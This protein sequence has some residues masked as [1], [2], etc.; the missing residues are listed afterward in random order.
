MTD[1]IVAAPQTGSGPGVAVLYA[2]ST[3]E[4]GMREICTA[5]GEEGY[6]AIAHFIPPGTNR[7]DGDTDSAD[8]AVA[9][10]RRHKSH[11]GRI[12]AISFGAAAQNGLAL[13]ANRLVDCLVLYE[14]SDTNNIAGDLARVHVPVA[15][16]LP[17]RGSG[18]TGDSGGPPPSPPAGT[19][20][21][22]APALHAYEGTRPGF[23]IPGNAAYN[24][25]QAAFAWS[26]TISTLK[27]A[28]GPHYSLEELWEYHLA[29][30]FR[31][32]DADAAIETMVAEPYVNHIP[33]LTGGYGSDRLR[34]FYAHHFVNQVP[35]D[36]RSIPISRTVGAD[37]I[38]DEK[39]FCFTHDSE[40]DWMLPGVTP[41]GR[42][43]EI[44]LV[45]I[46]TFRG[47][48]LVNEHIYWDQ[49]SVLVQTGLLDP[50]GL[51]VAGV[52]Q[53]RKLLDPS[54]PSNALIPGWRD[55]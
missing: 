13:A 38:V 6:V 36:R 54:L 15:I 53:A 17:V 42:Y 51:P 8:D 7:R 24:A 55:D 34:Q 19:A 22:T 1:D 43:V 2:D 4:A 41:T 47:S 20:N 33:T 45:G 52:E 40:I 46:V 9:A 10:L 26:R 48:R 21:S 49:A 12:G 29:C 14:P 25:P 3:L 16:H 11:R 18:A 27:R 23:A 44:P 32:Q 39:I 28:M 30:E 37:R 50:A 5:L 35:R 31:L